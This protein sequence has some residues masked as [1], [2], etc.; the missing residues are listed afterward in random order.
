LFSSIMAGCCSAVTNVHYDRQIHQMNSVA[1]GSVIIWDRGTLTVT[2][3]DKDADGGKTAHVTTSSGVTGTAVF[4]GGALSVT[5]SYTVDASR[6]WGLSGHL[7]NSY[8]PPAP[9]TQKLL[10]GT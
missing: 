10:F 1:V 5:L 8:K 4:R 6:R 7:R 2:A 3:V 9:D